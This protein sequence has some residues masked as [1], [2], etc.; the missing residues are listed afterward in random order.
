MLCCVVHGDL[1]AI[2]GLGCIS[3]L[4][5]CD[6]A[7]VGLLYWCCGA[8]VGLLY[9]CGGAAVRL[10]YGCGGAAVAVIALTDLDL[11]LTIFACSAQYLCLP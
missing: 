8:A 2:R 5:C 1:S 7:A 6:W 11:I 9:W 3:C 10:L 4:W